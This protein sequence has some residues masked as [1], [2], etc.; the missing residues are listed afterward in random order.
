MLLREAGEKPKINKRGTSPDPCPD[1]LAKIDRMR[2]ERI[3]QTA[4]SILA[5]AL[6]VSLKVHEIDCHVRNRHN[7]HGEYKKIRTKVDMIVLEDLSRYLTSQDR[8]R[9]ENSQLM[10]WCHRAILD[11]V[12]MFAEIYSIPVIEVSAAYSSKFSSKNAMPGFRAREISLAQAKQNLEIKKAKDREEISELESIIEIAEKKKLKKVIIPM[13]GG[14]LFVPMNGTV[15]QADI[16]AAINLGL[17]AVAEPSVLSIHHKVRT[18]ATNGI[19]RPRRDSV[20]EKALWKEDDF[21]N[22]K[23]QSNGFTGFGNCFNIPKDFVPNF[24]SCELRGMQFVT[25]KGL[26]TTIKEKQWDRIRELLNGPEE[27]P[28]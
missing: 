1:I 7:I 20:R 21:F 25:S 28:F 9:A 3:N 11:K 16:N 14:P 13:A 10:Q 12:K 17:R 26:W 5:E 18:Q 4:H 19:L 27:F 6:G 2:D 15:L 23:N 22:F 8:S 24:E